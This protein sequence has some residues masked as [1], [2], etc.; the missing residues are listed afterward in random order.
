MIRKSIYAVIIIFI[1][2]ACGAAVSPANPT[3]GSTPSATENPA[4]AQTTP[5][6]IPNTGGNT[7]TASPTTA[8][9][10]PTNTPA[11][12]SACTDSAS[13]VADVTIPDNTSVAGGTVFLKT[14]R[15]RNTGTCTWHEN[16]TLNYAVGDQMNSPISTPFVK[17]APGAT[18]DLSVSLT[19]PTAAGSYTGNYEI[20]DGNKQVV[21]IDNYK[22]MWV[23]IVVGST[24]AQNSASSASTG[25]SGSCTYQ[26][27]AALVSQ[28]YA[29]INAAREQNGLP[30]LAMSPTLAAIAMGHS[31]D[32]ACHSSLSHVGSDGSAVK[33]RFKSGGYTGSYA[34]EAVYARSPEAGGNAQIA[35]DW[36]LNDPSHRV[37]LLSPQATQIGAAYAYV[38]ESDYGGYYTIDFGTP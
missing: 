17:T 11:G 19:S 16:Y 15:L 1:L 23:K 24:A 12:Q 27:N 25:T 33:D 6:L 5:T 31:I 21:L 10:A 3:Q 28:L 7:P 34:N 13:L 22:Y 35:V 36:W 2:T 18:L 8:I 9:A 26:E 20:L 14:W 4:P 29:L 32:M 37:I 38:P 30:D